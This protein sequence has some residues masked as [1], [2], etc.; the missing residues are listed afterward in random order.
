MRAQGTMCQKQKRRLADYDRIINLS[1]K[2]LKFTT[3]PMQNPP[4]RT[5]SVLL[6]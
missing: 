4:H 6:P 3:I 2:L 1:F 5:F